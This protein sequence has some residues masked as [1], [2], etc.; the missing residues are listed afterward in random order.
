MTFKKQLDSF[1]DYYLFILQTFH[2]TLR[3]V[4]IFIDPKVNINNMDNINVIYYI[5]II[6]KY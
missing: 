1:Y 5:I 4:G 6:I 3:E 2:T